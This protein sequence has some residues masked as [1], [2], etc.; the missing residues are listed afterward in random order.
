MILL[1]NFKDK[2]PIL[3][4]IQKTM[5]Q[6]RDIQ[7]TLLFSI[8]R[9]DKSFIYSQMSKQNKTHFRPLD[10]SVAEEDRH[11]RKILPL[12]WIHYKNTKNILECIWAQ[13]RGT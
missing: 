1:F 9:L 4:D 8:S 11:Q 7:T 10:V 5:K 12:N 3:P 2:I 6:L 13:L